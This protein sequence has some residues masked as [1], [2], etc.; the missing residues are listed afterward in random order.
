MRKRKWKLTCVGIAG[1]M[2]NLGGMADPTTS[3]AAENETE[4][5]TQ[6]AEPVAK[7]TDETREVVVTANRYQTRELDAPAAMEILTSEDLEAT[8][9]RN[10]ADALR[11]SQGITYSTYGPGSSSMSSMTSKAVIRGVDSG[12][13]VLINGIPLNLRGLYNLEDIPIDLWNE[14]R[15]SEAVA[16]FFMAVR[17]LAGLLIS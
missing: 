6:T 10:I 1:G 11:Y 16:R 13:L 9:G 2:I 14:L 3:W 12:T 8:G 15:L 5:E 17:R 7:I 4:A